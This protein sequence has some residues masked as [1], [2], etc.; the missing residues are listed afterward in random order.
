MSDLASVTFT[1]L[2]PHADERGVFAEVFRESWPTG[3]G[4]VQWNLVTSR[5]NVLRGV[6][7][8]VTHADYL[9]CIAG[10]MMLVLNDTRPESPTCGKVEVHTL[11]ERELRAVTIP[12]GVAHGFYFAK[13]AMHIYAVSHYWDMRDELGCRW[14]DP[15]LRIDW[16]VADPILSERDRAAG[17]FDDMVA[18]FAERRARAEAGGL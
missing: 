10:E 5:A 11:S 9:M 17:G 4:P 7:V 16:G 2:T 1:R 3:I 12:P 14:N 18:A 13:P 15:A 8:H 6:H